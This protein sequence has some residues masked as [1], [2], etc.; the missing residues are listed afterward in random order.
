ML[1]Q[2]SYINNHFKPA[3][4]LWEATSYTENIFYNYT[5][6]QIEQLFTHTPARQQ[7]PII[8]SDKSI[9]AFDSRNR[10]PSCITPIKNSGNCAASWAVS[11]VDT[12]SDRLCVHSNTSIQ[13]SAQDMLSCDSSDFGCQGGFLDNAWNFLKNTGVTT[14][15]CKPFSSGNGECPTCSIKCD[16]SEEKYIK[17]K[18]LKQTYLSFDIDAMQTEIMAHGPLQ[19]TMDV[20]KDFLYYQSGIYVTDHKSYLGSQPIRIIGW[21]TQNSIKYWIAA[22]NWGTRWGENGYFR[23]AIGE[24]SVSSQMNGCNLA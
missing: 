9:P 2:N 7:L 22:N 21:G 23:I 12:F 16:N 14:E 8:D 11:T 5:D 18:C 24:C 3:S 10:W 20:Y 15:S 4:P 19:S 6:Q 13:L 1:R 17:Y